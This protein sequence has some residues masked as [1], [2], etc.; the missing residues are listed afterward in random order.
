MYDNTHVEARGQPQMSAVPFVLVHCCVLWASWP[1][2]FWGLFCPL[3]PPPSWRR[4]ADVLVVQYSPSFSSVLWVHTPGP[5]VHGDC[6]IH[7]PIFPACLLK[8]SFPLHWTLWYLPSIYCL[9]WFSSSGGSS[10]TC[11]GFRRP[12]LIAPIWERRWRW[13]VGGHLWVGAS[14][15]SNFCICAGG[16]CHMYPAQPRVSATLGLRAWL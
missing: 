3:S 5:I 10:P 16:T 13:E 15:Y 11:G 9:K 6:S 2:S 14:C 8:Y 7:G 12:S 4:R 1:A